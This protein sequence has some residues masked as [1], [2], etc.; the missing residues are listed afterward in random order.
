MQQTQS[1]GQ[2][3]KGLVHACISYQWLKCVYQHFLREYLNV[4]GRFNTNISK[5]QC[6]TD[7]MA[8]PSVPFCPSTVNPSSRTG[9]LSSC[10]GTAGLFPSSLI[11]HLWNSV[12]FLLSTLWVQRTWQQCMW[13]FNNFEFHPFSVS[14]CLDNSWPF[15]LPLQL[16]VPSTWLFVYMK[17]LFL[18][19]RL[20]VKKCFLHHCTSNCVSKP[21][22]RSAEGTPTDVSTVTETWET[23]HHALAVV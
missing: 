8:T 17:D 22:K 14:I 11:C 18:I 21:C 16:S 10:L 4:R 9:L 2:A 3:G 23:Q 7:K 6:F 15:F 20:L 5:S 12:S 19:F 13:V 1:W